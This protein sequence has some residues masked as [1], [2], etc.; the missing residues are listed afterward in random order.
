MGRAWTRLVRTGVLLG[1]VLGLATGTFLL[2]DVLGL[3]GFERF[4]AYLLVTTV[5]AAGILLY[6]AF[7]VVDR[8]N[9][10]LEDRDP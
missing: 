6:T 5:I 9:R 2:L 7:V 1:A 8:A 4:L 10:P 3:T